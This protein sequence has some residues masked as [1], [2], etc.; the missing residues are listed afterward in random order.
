MDAKARAQAEAAVKAVFA[1]YRK[2]QP[3]DPAMLATLTSGKF[4]ELYV[5]SQ[6]V[7]D[8][9]NRGF[10]LTFVGSMRPPSAASA[11]HS[12]LKFKGAPG[13]IKLSDSHFE[14]KVP[15]S[16]LPTYRLF[17]NIE[18]DTLGS[19]LNPVSDDSGRHELDIVLTQ[20]TSGYPSNDEILLGV[21]CKAVANFDKGLVKEALGVRREMSFLSGGQPSSLSL[22]CGG[23]AKI[24]SAKPPSEFILAYLDPKGDYYADSPRSFSIDFT[25]L[26]P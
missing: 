13:M 10:T 1:N 24:V 11:V 5:L 3:T 20:A 12:T 7:T 2:A 18:F 15:G 26:R 22:L 25:L 16:S 8:L 21:E 17:L 4:Y 23:P 9:D 14:V 19:K 6:V